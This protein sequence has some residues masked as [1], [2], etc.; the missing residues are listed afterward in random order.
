MK[1]KI[2]KY[3]AW[4]FSGLFNPFLIPT[5]GLWLIM[6]Y[7]PGV[8]FFSVKL[9]LI[10]L[11]VLFFSTCLL[12][13][14]FISLGKLHRGWNIESEHYLNRVMPYLFTALSAF[15]GSQLLGKLPVPGIFRVFLLAICLIMVIATLLS[16][17]WKVSEHLLALGGFLGSLLALNFKYGMNVF[18]L[19]VAVVLVSGIV[20][21]SRLYLEKES[22]KQ[23]YASFLIGM[24]CMFVLLFI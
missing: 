19:I 21:T 13:F 18:W 6:G 8:D 3:T 24:G 2:S 5:L 23:V 14:V 20:G 15:F 4:F 10:L 7:I 22:Q 11:G 17:K 9:K 1:E 12:P 16:F